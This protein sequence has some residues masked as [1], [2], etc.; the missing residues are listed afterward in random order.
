MSSTRRGGL[1]K[2]LGALLASSPEQQTEQQTGTSPAVDVPEPEGPSS[3]VES[4]DGLDERADQG[5][6]QG[7]DRGVPTPVAAP[8]PA[9]MPDRAEPLPT[10]PVAPV[11]VGGVRL[12][13]IDPTT[14]ERNP[15]QP[16]DVFDQ[17]EIDQLATSL[18]DVGMLQPLVVRPL[19]GD[20]YEL[21]AGERRMRAAIAAGLPTVPAIVRATED[22]DLLKEAL[23]E[24]IHRV[25]LNPLEEA[26]AYQQLLEDFGVTQEEL[27]ARLGRSRPTI[28]NTIRLLSLPPGVQRRIAAGVITAGHAKA[29]LSLENPASQQRLADRVVA[30]GLSVRATEESARLMQGD[31][32]A[33]GAAKGRGGGNRQRISVPGLVELQDDLSDALE[34]RVRINMG[35]RKG[36]LTVEFL[37]VDD[38]ERIVGVIADG[39]GAGPPAA[40]PA[41]SA[42]AT[43]GLS[44]AEATSAAARA[45]AAESLAQRRRVRFDDLGDLDIEGMRRAADLSDLDD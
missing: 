7:A 38:L 10:T 4:S 43:D 11:S 44:E 35:A 45:S 28:S 41:S 39:L 14:L 20:R 3:A 31:D 36:R 19:G 9:P 16:R 24:N 12:I 5:A 26:A 27:A 32:A 8:T 13:E 17:E 2:G 29:L 25:Q 18:L 37:S 21:V 23:V 6:D 22:A 42:I 33:A 1:G 30:E 40:V 34:A 15:R